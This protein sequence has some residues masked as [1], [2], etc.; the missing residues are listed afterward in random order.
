M[1]SASAATRTAPVLATEA[2]TVSSAT[3]SSVSSSA[4][5]SGT[6]SDSASGEEWL[7]NDKPEGVAVDEDV[8]GLPKEHIEENIRTTAVTV[9]VRVTAGKIWVNPDYPSDGYVNHVYQAD[10]LEVFRGKVSGKITYSVMADRDLPLRFPGHPIVLSL[11]GRDPDMYGVPDNGYEF[12]AAP[13]VLREARTCAKRKST[14]TH[15]A[16]A[17]Q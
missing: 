6:E 9:L 8:A 2:A 12:P 14:H 4:K 1:Q 13:R 17:C 5:P 16:T 7:R 11:C 10:V 15:P 3:P